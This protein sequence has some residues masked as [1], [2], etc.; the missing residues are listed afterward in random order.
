V[1]THFSRLLRHSWVNGGTITVCNYKFSYHL[2]FLCAVSIR[3]RKGKI[4]YKSDTF[5]CLNLPEIVDVKRIEVQFFLYSVKTTYDINEPLY[6][7][8]CI[9]GMIKCSEDND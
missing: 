2:C 3:H 7:P 5:L 8:G 4:I 9:Q 6:Q 1:A